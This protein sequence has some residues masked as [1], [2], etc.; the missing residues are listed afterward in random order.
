MADNVNITPGSGQ[1]IA[2]DEVNDATL[3]TVAVQYVK[4]MDGTLNGTGKASVSGNGLAVDPKTLPPGA[5]TAAKQAAPGTAGSP[6]VDV[7]STQGVDGGT[8]AAVVGK[9]VA[10]NATLTRPADT[11]AYTALDAISDSVSSPTVLT[12]NNVARVNNGS[13]YL[14]KLRMMTN[15][16][17]FIG[18]IRLH[19]FHTAP[20]AINDNAAC[21]LLWANRSNR[22]GHITLDAASTEG[23]GSDAANA[24]AISI[25]LPFVCAAADRNIYALVETL[26]GFT[27]I[28]GQ[29]F[30]F[31]LTAELN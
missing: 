12:F 1:A 9:T 22:I 18:R 29:N 5:A 23:S 15:Q 28:S 14:T 21:T 19:L 10:V 8:P 27:P 24:S 11:N 26:D 6:S 13:G 31:E 25:R 4:I 17:T 7:Y 30:F 16:S 3:G 2:A 20:T